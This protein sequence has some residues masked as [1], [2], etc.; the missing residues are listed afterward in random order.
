MMQFSG[1]EFEDIYY[2]PPIDFNDF[3]NK[4]K[5][6]SINS[7]YVNGTLHMIPVDENPE[8]MEENTRVTFA[9]RFLKENKKRN[10]RSEYDNYHSQSEQIKN[11][12][13]RNMARRWAERKGLVKKGDGKDIDHKNGNPKDNSPSNLRVRSRSANRADND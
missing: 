8:N 12:S 4:P 5:T 10:Y 11:R 13:K 3:A 9:S 2:E 6:S 7:V 1:L